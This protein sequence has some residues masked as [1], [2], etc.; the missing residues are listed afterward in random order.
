MSL[1]FG[2]KDVH[3]LITGAAGGIGLETVKIFSQLGT[4]VTAHYNT[5]IGE[6]EGLKDVVSLQAD[7]R[8]EASV[9]K[10]LKEAAEQNH[11]PVSILVVNHG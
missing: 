7:V 10:L 1:D 9:N 5:K 11:G 8:D 3:V 6:L 4:R 2:L